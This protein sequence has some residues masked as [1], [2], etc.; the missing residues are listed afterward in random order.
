ML[1][2]AEAKQR[3]GVMDEAQ[4]K[5]IES[6]FAVHLQSKNTFAYKIYLKS[7]LKSR[8]VAGAFNEWLIGKL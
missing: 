5:E 2:L 8:A 6:R 4:Q 7:G 1:R 3:Y